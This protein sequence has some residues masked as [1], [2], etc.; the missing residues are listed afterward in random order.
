MLIANLLKEKK[1]W[2]VNSGRC[3]FKEIGGIY[4]LPKYITKDITTKVV[5]KELSKYNKLV[6]RLQQKDGY[7]S[8]EIMTV[9]DIIS[10]RTDAEI[11]RE[12][13]RLQKLSDKK[14]QELV[15]YTEGGVKVPRFV[16]EYIAKDVE[17]ANKLKERIMK[18]KSP[19]KEA[20][21]LFLIES[22]NLKPL[23]IGTGKTLEEIEK[24]RRTAR[25]RA[26]KSY[27]EAKGELYKRG[28][29]DATY[30]YLGPYAGQIVS[31]ISKLS[32][33][34]LFVLSL[35]TLHGADLSIN[36]LYGEEEQEEKAQ[37]INEALD[38][39]GV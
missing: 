27:I 32:G 3:N 25:T 34:E 39:L 14:Q 30:A 6:K 16:R 33:N 22:E 4:F 17:R 36:F 1:H 8:L 23:T 20:G 12:L 5:K 18:G 9:K 28:Y 19:S 2:P 21:N 29:I 13:N 24:R 31:R 38:Y 37:I 11:V 15:D 10:N 26:T 35:D 7:E